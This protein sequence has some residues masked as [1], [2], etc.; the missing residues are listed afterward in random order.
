M[1]KNL[2]PSAG[3]IRNS[4]SDPG[5]GRSPGGGHGNSVAMAHRI[6]K[7]GHDG[8]SLRQHST[9]LNLVPNRKNSWTL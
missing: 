1:V 2:L 7:S 4:D 6:A 9:N 3:D 8:S 5:L